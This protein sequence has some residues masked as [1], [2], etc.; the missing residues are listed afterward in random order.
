[1]G[2]SGTTA[3]A[4]VHAA[5]PIIVFLLGVVVGLSSA[6]AAQESQILT[7]GKPEEVGMSGPALKAAVS[8][9]SEAAARGDIL[10]VVL[11]V[12]RRGKVVVYEAIGMRDREKNLPMEKDTPFQIMSMTKPVV[13]SATLI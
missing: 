3:R 4:R 7:I 5:R 11:L 13:A 9:Y 8:L 1:M 2:I 12:A 6:G 10:G